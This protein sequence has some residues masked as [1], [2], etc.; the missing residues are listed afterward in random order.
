MRYLL[1]SNILRYFTGSQPNLDYHLARIPASEIGIPFFVV[2]E[3]LRGRF[4]AYLKAA[5]ENLLREQTRLLE[6]QAFLTN[7]QTVYATEASVA[8]LQ[9]L[10][11]KVSTHKRYVDVMIAS[12]AL[13]ENATVVTRNVEDFRDLLPADKIQNWIDDRH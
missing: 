6:T 9:A 4:D 8:A 11:Q 10:R 2:I 1:D 5:P 12:L 13:A 7:Y 3:Q